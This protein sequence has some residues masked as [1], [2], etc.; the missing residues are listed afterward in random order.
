MTAG[1]APYSSS[2]AARQAWASG[3]AAMK[4]SR[5][6]AAAA[7]HTALAITP[8]LYWSR[9]GAPCGGKGW[10]QQGTG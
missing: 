1:E 4:A 2:T 9:E 10:R 8:Q 5:Q 6:W 3:P 7:T